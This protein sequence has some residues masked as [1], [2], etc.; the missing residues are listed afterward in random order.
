MLEPGSAFERA[1]R[2]A[3]RRVTATSRPR[4]SL[5]A[6]TDARFYGR[7]YGIPSLCYGATGTGSHGFDESVDLESI[8]KVTP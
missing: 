3:H 7:Y 8:K 1:V 6:V 2:D 4:S 5:P